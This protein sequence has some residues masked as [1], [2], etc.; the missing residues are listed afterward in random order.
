ML[1]E[2][3]DLFRSSSRSAASCV[4]RSFRLSISIARQSVGGDRGDLLA[5]LLV[6][7]AEHEHALSAASIF[8][9]ATRTSSVF[10]TRHAGCR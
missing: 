4:V 3:D 10:S 8:A 2:L 9:F 6:L 1:E 5:Q 7:A